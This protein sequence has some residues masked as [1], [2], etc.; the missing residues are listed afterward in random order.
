MVGIQRRGSDA[1]R[2]LSRE[3]ILITILGIQSKSVI[4]TRWRKIEPVRFSR[5]KNAPFQESILN[6]YRPLTQPLWWL[7]WRHF[8]Y[9]SSANNCWDSH[10]P[11]KH[12]WWGLPLVFH[13]RIFSWYLR[14]CITHLS[15]KLYAHLLLFPFTLLHT[16]F[17]RFTCFSLISAS[18]S[19]STHAYECSEQLWQH[20][21]FTPSPWSWDRTQL[22]L[23]PRWY[24]EE[25]E[26]N[27]DLWHDLALLPS[28]NRDF[29]SVGFELNFAVFCLLAEQNRGSL[30]FTGMCVLTA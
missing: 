14:C 27:S 24:G 10:F 12:Y 26:V 28:P 23:C 30:G 21:A 25:T 19:I 7:E 3:I 16:G 29:L 22:V 20:T 4:Q 8:C 13:P 15:E 5:R 11:S 18:V 6:H 9:C 2:E 17:P 1:V